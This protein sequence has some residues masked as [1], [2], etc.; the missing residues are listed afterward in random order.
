MSRPIQPKDFLNRDDSESKVTQIPKEKYAKIVEG[1]NRF[2]LLSVCGV[3]AFIGITAMPQ[4][5]VNRCVK[6]AYKTYCR[7]KVLDLT[8]KLYDAEDVALLELSRAVRVEFLVEE[9]VVDDGHYK[10]DESL[11]E[12]EKEERRRSMTLEYMLRNDHHWVG[13]SVNFGLIERRKTLEKE[14][15][16]YDTVI[17]RDELLNRKTEEA[18]Q[19]FDAGHEYLADDG[20]FIVMDYG[21]SSNAF[22][23]DWMRWFNKFSESSMCFT[24]NYHEWIQESLLYEVVE[25]RRAMFGFYYTLVLKRRTIE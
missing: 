5:F 9:V 1:R 22:L 17:I 12:K 6:H 21:K 19:L 3:A 15:K 10:I 4:F 20:H 18:R 2:F 13:S 23:A 14:F 25:E 8:P 24:H 7:G 11:S 16:K